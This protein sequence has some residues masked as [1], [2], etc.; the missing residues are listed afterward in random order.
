MA[1]IHKTIQ[2]PRPVAAV[3]D[4]VTTPGNWPQ[5]HPS[6]RGVR[7]VTEHSLAVGEQ[8]AEVFQ[9]GWHRG[10]VVWTCRERRAPHHWVIDGEV[11]GG[12]GGTITYALAPDGTGTRFERT[13]VYTM[14]TRLLVLLDRLFIRHLMEA[15]SDRALRQLKHAVEAL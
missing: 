3:F 4:F 8:V 12:G 1:R 15:S 5:W 11:E 6:S 9:V 10:R 14:P 13:F 2:I 7:G